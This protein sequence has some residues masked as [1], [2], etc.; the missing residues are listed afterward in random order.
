MSVVKK[1]VP[2]KKPLLKSKSKNGKKRSPLHPVELSQIVRDARPPTP[3]MEFIVS[4]EGEME[5]LEAL[6]EF[7]TE[8]CDHPKNRQE[9]SST[10]YE[11]HKDRYEHSLRCMDCGIIRPRSGRAPSAGSR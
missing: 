4:L 6:R 11:P 2:K 1:K 3:L 8:W 10:L 9:V 5:Y 7:Q